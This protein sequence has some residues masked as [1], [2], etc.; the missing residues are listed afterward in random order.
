MILFLFKGLI[1]D[2]SRS[3]FP[4]LTVTLGVMLTVVLYSW[5]E[6]L[7]GE[8]V[9][10]SARF[11]T[12]HVKVTTRGYA[13]EV[14]QFPNDLCLF[15]TDSLARTLRHRYPGLLWSPRIRFGGLLDIPDEQGETRAQGP[16]AGFA[17][18]L[19]GE[20]KP[21]VRILNLSQA[22]VRGRLPAGKGEA[23]LSDEFATRLGVR[24]GE[25]ATLIGATRHGSLAT[26][27]F[28]IAGTIRFGI[29]ILDRGTIVADLSDV[30]SALDMTDA[31]GELFGFF[32][33]E[34]YRDDVANAIAA[35]FNALSP[36]LTDEFGPEMVTLRNQAG[37]A[38]T[39]DVWAYLT[40]IL[41]LIFVAVMSIVLWNAGLMASLRRYGEIGM[42][43]AL[44]EAKG[45]IYR[46]MLAESVMIGF[47]GSLLGT[48]LGIGVAYYLQETGIDIGSMMKNAS[49]MLANVLRARV[50][51]ASY[52][53]GFVPGLCATLLGTS[54]AGIGIYRRQTAQL[55]KEL[56][57]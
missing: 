15:G 30:Q 40:S 37:L 10:A 53:I 22:L 50:T 23:L 32:A 26:A 20:E 36:D 35:D 33:D 11:A 48:A 8:L 31:A 21:D 46:A 1:R 29:T 28:T 9:K 55:A 12:G 4:V 17:F 56:Q 19:L 57:S 13:R 27:N 52:V 43:L 49:I 42:R 38:Q 3:F 2:P 44:G 6:G 25:T 18:D 24:I 47:L 45:R 5:I 54:I 34:L 51:P 14:D 41:V 39:L 16:V 7:Q